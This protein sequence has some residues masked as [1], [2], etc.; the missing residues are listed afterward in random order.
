MTGYRYP[1]AALRGDYIRAGIGTLFM[2]GLMV[3]AHAVPVMAVL[4]GGLFLVFLGFGLQ[5]FAR[6]M[7]MLDIE[8]EGLRIYGLRRRLLRWDELTG[9]RLRFFSVKRER[10]SGWMEL[11][12]TA[13]G[14]KQRID[15]SLDG[16]SDIARAV[17]EAVEGKGIT[18][19]ETSVENFRA[20]GI[21]TASPGLPEAAKRFDKERPWQQD[22]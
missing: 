22:I 15:S 12:L 19:D 4:V 20:L 6:H 10:S 21:Q 5:T 1:V 7:T 8:P 3:G 14:G 11:T 13:K 9:V 2:G 18:I 17:A 16:F